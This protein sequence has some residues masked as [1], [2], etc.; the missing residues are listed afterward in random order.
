MSGH[1][2]AKEIIDWIV[3]IVIAVI[4]GFLIV[5]FVAQRTVVFK[6]SMEPT[7]QEGDNLLVEKISPRLGK[8]YPG[9]IVVIKHA[10]PS[11]SEEGKEI[12]KRII[13]VEGDKVEIKDGKVII[14][15]KVQVEKYIKG[16]QTPAGPNPEHNNLVVPKGHVYVLGDNRTNSAD[17]RTMGPIEIKKIHGKAILRFYPFKKFGLLN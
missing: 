17:S 9:D 4:I 14:N 7:L 15:G 1:S 11:F 10:T 2:V 12:I 5:T 3:H 6:Y 8:F 13:A 16:D